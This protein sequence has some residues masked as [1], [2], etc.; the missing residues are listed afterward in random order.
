MTG[1]KLFSGPC[2]RATPTD[3]YGL[4]IEKISAR[5]WRGC[6]L[7]RDVQIG[8]VDLHPAFLIPDCKQPP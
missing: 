3:Q 2:F 6:R 8:E 7:P 5:K 4:Y 1:L